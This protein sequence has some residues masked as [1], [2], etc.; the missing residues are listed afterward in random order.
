[1]RV[2]ATI[3][4]F[5]Q[6]DNIGC[7]LSSG[8][9]PIGSAGPSL[10]VPLPFRDDV[11]SQV[12]ALFPQALAQQSSLNSHPAYA[13]FDIVA[14]FSTDANVWFP[15]DGTPIGPT[16]TDFRWVALH[17][18]IHGL[19]FGISSWRDWT[20]P[21]QNQAQLLT[22]FPVSDVTDYIWNGFTFN[23]QF[24]QTAFDIGLINSALT[25]W[26]LGQYKLEGVVKTRLDWFDG[27]SPV[28]FSTLDQ[29][30]SAL[31]ASPAGSLAASVQQIVH[32]LDRGVGFN[33]NDGGPMLLLSTGPELSSV[34]SASLISHVDMDTYT[35]TT[36]FLM[37]PVVA[38]GLT[39]EQKWAHVAGSGSQM[40]LAGGAT[41]RVLKFLGYDIVAPS[42][43]FFASSNADFFNQV[44]EMSVPSAKHIYSN[45]SAG[46]LT[47][48]GPMMTSL[49]ILF[50]MVANLFA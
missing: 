40:L 28:T 14:R 48:I 6:V 39:L 1:L 10:L 43:N 37:T 7:D 17:E 31:V 32:Q 25:G 50:A 45:T 12:S 24:Y 8:F 11:S 29:F 30:R 44:F 15:E 33:P 35:N 20:V 23:G 41:E 27:N 18:T 16:Q 3:Y 9:R 42:N 47:V 26:Q 46:S 21:D 49:S 13:P 19:G 22:P 34:N 38:S 5:C 4:S 36:S 2:N